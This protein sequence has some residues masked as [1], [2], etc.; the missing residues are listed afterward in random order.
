MIMHILMAVLIILMAAAFIIQAQAE[1][2]RY[3]RTASVGATPQAVYA[4]VNDLHK[5]QAWSP[6]AKMDPTAKNA[7]EGPAEGAGAIMRWAGN[8]KVGE[9]CMTILESR[10]GELIRIKLEFLK[11][12]QATH[13][14]E[15][16]FKPEGNQTLVTWS[17]YGKNNFMGKAMGLFMNCDKMIGGQFST[18]LAWLKEIVEGRTA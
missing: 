4:Q 1:D 16:T 17:M 2:F 11:P 14:A 15:F 13:T 18:G 8:T 5:W 6:W 7:F 10:P 3:T 9:G 12:F